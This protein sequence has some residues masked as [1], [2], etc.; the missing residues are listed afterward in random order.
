MFM[1]MLAIKCFNTMDNPLNVSRET[2]V[3]P[4]RQ[5]VISKNLSKLPKKSR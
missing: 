3:D 4:Q 1:L 2:L 5:F